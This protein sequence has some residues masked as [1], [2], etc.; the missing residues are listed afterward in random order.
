[1]PSQMFRFRIS[2]E[3]HGSYRQAVREGKLNPLVVCE[4][5]RKELTRIVLG[6]G[7]VKPHDQ[8][9]PQGQPPKEEDRILTSVNVDE[10]TSEG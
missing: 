1:M 9:T 3:L 10:I 2:E 7:I 8:T 6:A 4:T 5:L